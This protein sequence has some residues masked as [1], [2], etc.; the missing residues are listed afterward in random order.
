MAFNNQRE[1]EY[2]KALDVIF[3]LTAN[4]AVI[5]A[6]AIGILLGQQLNATEQNSLGNF[7]MLI[8]QELCTLGA[9]NQ[10]VQSRRGENSDT[11][12]GFSS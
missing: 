2:E 9:Q 11:N 3:N 1:T 7:L 4:E 5:Y 6:S 8:A 10:M 12:L